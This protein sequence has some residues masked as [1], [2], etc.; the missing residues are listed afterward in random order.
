MELSWESKDLRGRCGYKDHRASII[1]SKSIKLPKGTNNHP[2][3][4]ALLHGL[5]LEMLL[6]ITTLDIE[7]D[8]LIIINA[9]KERKLYC[10]KIRYVL[11]QAWKLI[12]KLNSSQLKYKYRE[13]NLLEDKLANLGC[14]QILDEIVYDNNSNNIM[15]DIEEIMQK[16]MLV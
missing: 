7:G 2:E 16:E 4:K 3:S 6:K 11:E 8:S 9:Y 1:S 13:V 14:D 5:H 15:Q 12:D 10:W